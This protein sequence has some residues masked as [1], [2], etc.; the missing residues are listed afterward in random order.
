MFTRIFKYSVKNIFRNKFLSLS[1]I[2]VL[3]LLMFFINILFVVHDVSLNLIEGISEK[4]TISLYL[5]DTETESYN[6]NSLEVIELIDN[7]NKVEWNI[8]VDY[9]SREDILDEISLTEPDLAKILERTNPLP[10]T[11]VLSNIDLEEYGEL[12][13]VIENKSF[14]LS[15]QKDDVEHF[16]NYD[17]QYKKIE[18]IIK[19]LHILQIWLYVIIAIFLVSISVII[20]S[21][22]GN[23]IYY[24]KDEIYITRLVGWSKVFIYWPFTYQWIIY[25]LASFL[26]SLIIFILIVS[27]FNTA[28]DS[29]YLINIPSK[30]FFI[31]ML[32][33]VFIWGISGFL[34][35]MKYLKK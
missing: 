33:F 2:L 4:L 34:S 16:S 9:K 12:N 30:I 32:I 21:I 5:K 8:K 10:N 27:N 26:L 29:I 15:N 25:S 13:D 11:I 7:I 1:S 14:I 35:S 22:I 23:F 19:V 3:T 6:R 20:Y 31:E 18:Q 24:Y 17:V 28:F